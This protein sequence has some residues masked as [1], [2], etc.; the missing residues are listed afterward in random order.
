MSLSNRNSIGTNSSVVNP[1]NNSQPSKK[2]FWDR[3]KDTILVSGACGAFLGMA[4][5]MGIGALLGPYTFGL[6][7]VL[8]SILGGLIGGVLGL[9][10]TIAI[11]IHQDKKNPL[12]DKD[13]RRAYAGM[14]V[15]LSVGFMLGMLL[16]P[17]TVGASILAGT[18][19]GSLIGGVIGIYDAWRSHRLE[20]KWIEVASGG[21]TVE[22]F[23]KTPPGTPKPEINPTPTPD[24]PPPYTP[25]QNP[26]AFNP[27]V[28]IT[29]T[30]S[31]YSSYRLS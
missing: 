25:P 14:T 12:I 28:T 27:E 26:P 7:F 6:G 29:T 1:K 9:A 5:G 15:G 8:C 11:C 31:D 24:V 3:H 13:I 2:S 4:I 19:V 17:F 21:S 20:T 22:V 16:V 18:L 23:R 10:T 30:Y